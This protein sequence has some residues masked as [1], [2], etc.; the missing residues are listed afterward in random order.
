MLVRAHVRLRLDGAVEREQTVDRQRE[1]ARGDR[2]PEIGAHAA[3]DLAHLIERTSAK[4]DADIVDPAQRMQIE[5]EF[6]LGA[7]EAAYV[8]DAAENSGRLHGLR[9]HG[10]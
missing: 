9:D 2:V 7:G 5:V 8:D 1:L 10:S 3:A 4:G 6:G